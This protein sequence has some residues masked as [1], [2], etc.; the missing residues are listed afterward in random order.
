MLSMH[1][2]MWQKIRTTKMLL[3]Q[4]KPELPGPL[5][6]QIT[7]LKLY[8]GCELSQENGSAFRLNVNRR[9]KAL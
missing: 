2:L 4:E 7:G 3:E 8:Q 1:M 9:F 6:S 5:I